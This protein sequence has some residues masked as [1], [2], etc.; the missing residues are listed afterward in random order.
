M[1]GVIEMLEEKQRNIDDQIFPKYNNFEF[2]INSIQDRLNSL[3]SIVVSKNEQKLTQEDLNKMFENNKRVLVKEINEKFSE[4]LFHFE[5]KL[6]Q[7]SSHVYSNT[8]ELKRGFEKEK[9][10]VDRKIKKIEM[11]M[12]EKISITEIKVLMEKMG[13]KVEDVEI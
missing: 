12:G 2:Q 5:N 10:E 4:N 7:Q 11:E 9:D 8:E 13:R 6:E 1:E 3:S